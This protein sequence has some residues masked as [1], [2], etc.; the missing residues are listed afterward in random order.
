ML[1]I[2]LKAQFFDGFVVTEDE[3]DRSH[4]DVDRNVFFDILNK[5]YV[6]Q[7]GIMTEL[8]LVTPEHIFTIDWAVLPDNTRP[9]RFKH[10]ERDSVDGEWTSEPRIMGVDFGYQ[11][12]EKFVNENNALDE[13]NVQKVIKLV[14]ENPDSEQLSVVGNDSIIA[15]ADIASIGSV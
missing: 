10:M 15:T 7:H 11:Y 4:F 8:A 6:P 14:R 3:Q 1:D 13:R 9:I 2:Y 12:T 5:L